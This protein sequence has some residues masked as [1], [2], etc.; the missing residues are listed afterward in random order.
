MGVGERVV[1]PARPLFGAPSVHAEFSS[2]LR[3]P[4]RTTER[5]APAGRA[6]TPAA[7]AGAS[8]RDA[9]LQTTASRRKRPRGDVDSF[10][11][12]ARTGRPA[13]MSLVAG[14]LPPASDEALQTRFGLRVRFSDANWPPI[15]A[16]RLNESTSPRGRFRLDAVVCSKASRTLAAGRKA[17]VLARPAGAA[18]PVVRI[19]GLGLDE[20]SA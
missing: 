20:N 1:S 15:P 3:P 4:M 5:A 14:L 7:R 9:L 11:R 8:A 6:K 16:E 19:G 18:G 2:R 13:R 17:G 12:S 10:S